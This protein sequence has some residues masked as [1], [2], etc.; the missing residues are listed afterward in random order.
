MHT[1]VTKKVN[2]E[3]KPVTHVLED[4]LHKRYG[5]LGLLHQVVLCILDL[6]P[7]SVGQSVSRGRRATER[8]NLACSCLAGFAFFNLWKDERTKVSI[9]II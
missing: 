6:K 2:D 1:Y 3:E 8:T 9:G 5:N 7:V 4:S